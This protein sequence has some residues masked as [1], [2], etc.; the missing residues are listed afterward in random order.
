MG[1][2]G[3]PTM[4]VH[5][6]VGQWMCRF[7]RRRASATVGILSEAAATRSGEQLSP[8]TSDAL[9]AVGVIDHSGVAARVPRPM[10]MLS[11]GTTHLYLVVRRVGLVEVGDAHTFSHGRPPARVPG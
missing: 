1:G 10:T 11:S 5:P 4:P 7:Q 3:V 6:G 9:D 8:L 2:Y